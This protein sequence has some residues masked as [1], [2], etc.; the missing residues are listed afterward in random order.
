LDD[1]DNLFDYFMRS[2]FNFRGQFHSKI[3]TVTADAEQYPL[4]FLPIQRAT[5]RQHIRRCQAV[6]RDVGLKTGL[7]HRP[8]DRVRAV[9]HGCIHEYHHIEPTNRLGDVHRELVCSLKFNIRQTERSQPFDDKPTGT[10]V[11]TALVAI[12]DNQN[13]HFRLIE[14]AYNRYLP[15]V[16]P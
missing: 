15:Q 11:A 13:L 7:Y 5:Q 16:S 3:E 1:L 4:R 14:V 2:L 12:S 10:V 9:R 6:R 8:G